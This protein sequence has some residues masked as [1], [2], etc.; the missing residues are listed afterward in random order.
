MTSRKLFFQSSRG[1]ESSDEEPLLLAKDT[2]RNHSFQQTI[3][4]RSDIFTSHSLFHSE[5]EKIYNYFYLSHTIPYGTFSVL[6]PESALPYSSLP[7]VADPIQKIIRRTTLASLGPETRHVHVFSLR[8][9]FLLGS[10]TV[11]EMALRTVVTEMCSNK[12]QHSI[13]NDQPR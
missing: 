10:S 3:I 7:F 9:V 1:L 8:L 4:L 12:Q 13:S 5:R 2:F 6:I 11:P